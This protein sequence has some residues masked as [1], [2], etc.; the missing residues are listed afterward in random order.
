MPT[1]GASAGHGYEYMA[2]RLWEQLQEKGLDPSQ[3][4]E[5]SDIRRL[6]E[7]DA[8]SIDKVVHQIAADP[9]HGFYNA[10]GTNVLIT[11][12]SHM[13]INA[14]GNIQ[15][16][17]AVKAPEDAPVTPSYP[18]AGD[19]QVDAIPQEASPPIEHAVPDAEQHLEQPPI[20]EKSFISNKFGLAIPVAEP[21]FYTD[22]GAKHLFVYGGSPLERAN[23]IQEYLAEKPDAVVFSADDSGKYRIPWHL[24][25][26]KAT[27]EAPVQTRGF[28]SL[29]GRPFM[30]A[31]EP[32]EFEKSIK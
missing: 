2:K 31:P 21:H 32:N 17:D 27:P 28:F 10:D 4:A 13:T 11:L 30:K 8:S 15:L 9:E 22:P 26:G 14:D 16:D 18:P 3:Y 5:G 6:I 19:A 29:F 25:D 23:A 20:I 1:V 7:A 12:D 24:V